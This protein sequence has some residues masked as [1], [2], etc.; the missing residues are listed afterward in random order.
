MG[1]KKTGIIGAALASAAALAFAGTAQA[2]TAVE[3]TPTTDY[4]MCGTVYTGA[5]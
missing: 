3:G 1:I 4:Q 2:A 5:P